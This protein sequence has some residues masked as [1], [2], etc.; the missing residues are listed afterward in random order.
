MTCVECPVVVDVFVVVEK[1][2]L[3]MEERRRRKGLVEEEER[4]VG[5][6]RVRRVAVV[7]GMG[8]SLTFDIVFG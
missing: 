2:S 3:V 5:R 4:W 6:R 8:C 7:V 1:R